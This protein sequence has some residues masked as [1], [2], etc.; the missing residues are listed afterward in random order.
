[1]FVKQRKNGGFLLNLKKRIFRKESLSRYID[2]D[3]HF[4]KTLNAIDLI[5]LGIGA[6][7]GAG[8][9]ILP[10]TVAALHSGPSIVISF[11]LAAI[12]CSMAALCYAEFSAALPVAGSAY[13]FGNVVFGEIIG[14]FL[15]WALILEYMLA[16]AAVST[17]WAAYFKSFLDGFGI[18]IPKAISGNFDPNNGTYINL[19]AVLIVILI[20]FMLTRGVKSSIKI[21]NLIV[22][23]KLIIIALFLIVGTFYIKPHN[24]QPFM[25][26]GVKGIF[27]G[28]TSVFLH[29]SVLMPSLHQLPKLKILEKTCP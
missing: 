16:V 6:V 25:P 7:I 28:A 5:S 8:I 29:T 9:F 11:I 20:S 21:N 14:W 27:V 3:K 19:F 23:I 12:V 24:W 15:G 2:K 17:G 13:S 22:L 1:M 18:Q 26:F 4:V 10:G